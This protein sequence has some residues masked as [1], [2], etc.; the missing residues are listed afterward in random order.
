VLL[1]ILLFVRRRT[2]RPGVVSG[3]FLAGYGALRFLVEFV[4]APD[5]HIGFELLGMTRGQEY[6]L[7]F[8]AAGLAILVLA[9][10]VR[11]EAGSSS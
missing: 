1:L 8:V 6:S 10:R 9:G 5:P 3:V 2:G 7:L 4:R 11:P